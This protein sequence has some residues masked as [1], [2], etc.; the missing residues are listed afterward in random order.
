MFF[1]ARAEGVGG[2]EAV[3][4]EQDKLA[5]GVGFIDTGRGHDHAVF[6]REP[7]VLGVNGE[8]A[9][10]LNE[11]FFCLLACDVSGAPFGKPHDF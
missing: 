10:L 6:H 4:G 3:F 8:R 5:V 11:F 7:H 2:F 1:K 9:F